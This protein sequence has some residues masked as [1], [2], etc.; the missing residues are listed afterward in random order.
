MTNRLLIRIFSV[1][2]LD[3]FRVRLR[4]TN[5][6][7]R[8][9]D[10][11]RYLRGPIFQ[12]IRDDPSRFREVA[13]DARAGTIAWPNGADVDPDVLYHGLDPER[14]TPP[15]GMIGNEAIGVAPERSPA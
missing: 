3:G 6:E 13:I 14:A 15:A 1:S 10:L 8:D 2:V 7:E 11:A 12:S 4:F 9:V 5:G